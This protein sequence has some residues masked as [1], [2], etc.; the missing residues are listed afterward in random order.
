MDNKYDFTTNYWRVEA[1][2]NESFSVDECLKILKKE[3]KYLEQ[4][5]REKLDY[6]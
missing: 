1:E 6:Y 3:R 5:E 2:S 4:E